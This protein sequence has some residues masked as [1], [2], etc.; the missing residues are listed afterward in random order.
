MNTSTKPSPGSGTPADSEHGHKDT[1]LDRLAAV[2]NVAQFVSFAPDL[3]QRHSRIRGYAPNH[4]FQ[5]PEDATA[6]LLAASPEGSVNIRSYTP[7]RPKS[8]EFVYGVRSAAE[9]ARH[10]RRLAGEGLYTIAN[11]TID[12]HDGGVS[13]V[14]FG[15]LLEFAPGD[16]PRCVEKPGTVAFP[17]AQGL[18]VLE[19]VYGFRPALD[20]D[21]SVRVEFSLHPLRRGVRQDHTIVWE[22]EPFSSTPTV[23]PVRWPN[24]FSR[25]LGDKAFGLLVADALGL[26]VPAT[27]I[28]ARAVPPVRF[29]R[30][31]GTGET[32]LRTCPKEQVPGKFTTHHGW[33]DPFRLL[34]DE[35]PAG[36]QLA[37]ILA[38]EGIEA[39]YSGALL[40]T[41]DGQPLIEGVAGRGDQFMLGRAAPAALPA[42]MEERIRTLW[43]RARTHVGP[44]RIEWVHDAREPWVVQLHCGASLS[45]RDEIY[46]GDASHFVRF[47]VSGGLDALRSLIE[48]V[49]GTKEGIVL[50]GDVGITSHMGDLLRK[51]EIPSRLERR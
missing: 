6:A 3:R 41:A 45:T 42:A 48:R 29:G 47:P 7:E 35:D 27:T 33:V 16:T 1:V 18:R 21:P 43:D 49:R 40:T 38:Q 36:D 34:T 32:W 5:G 12:V 31:A 24:H 8:R 14:I 23:P 39:H 17:R 11:E 46:P 28:I 9:A 37:S 15:D 20:F 4:R 30:P 44:V 51:A 19:T 13:G 25:L 10:I 26:P 2:A 22:M 50:V